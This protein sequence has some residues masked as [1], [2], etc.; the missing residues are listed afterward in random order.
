MCVY[1]SE[2]NA[3][4]RCVQA[5]AT[6]LFV[7]LCKVSKLSELISA[8]FNVF[9]SFYNIF[10]HYII[11]I[12]RPRTNPSMVFSVILDAVPGHLLPDMG[13]GSWSV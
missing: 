8:F 2:Y 11:Q 9:F 1:S 10:N 7:Q 4:W 12:Y 13:G 5:G 3:F 6:Y